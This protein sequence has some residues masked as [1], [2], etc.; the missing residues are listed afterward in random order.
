MLLS[1]A[2]SAGALAADVN[3]TAKDLAGNDVKVPDAKTSVVAFVRADQEQSKQ[4]L[5]QIQSSANDAQVVIVLSGPA[6]Q[7]NA[8]ALAGTLPRTWHVVTDA[9]FAASGKMNIHVWPTT[10]VV[11]S[12]GAQVAHLAGA[13]KSFA[14]DLAAHLDFAN[15]KLDESGLKA[16]LASNDVITDSPAQV[17]SRH[18]QVAQRLV[19][20]GQFDLAQAELQVGLKHVPQDPA[21]LLLLARVKVLLNQPQDAMTVLDGLPAGAAPSAQLNLVRGRALIG[22]GKWSDAKL[23]L[24]EA[25]KLNPDPAEAHYLLG[26]CLEHEKDFP[27]AAE[28]Y[29]LAFE[30]ST[31]G[32]KVKVGR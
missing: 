10:L 30:T 7:D 32:A 11:K 17:A 4:A 5:K 23:S 9:D 2:I 3:W 19:E 18:L 6:A 12:D 26:V 24:T 16:R 22:L 31:G 13:P 25:L 1:L 29:R 14:A 20:R 8:M 27:A 15:G 21:S 28:Q